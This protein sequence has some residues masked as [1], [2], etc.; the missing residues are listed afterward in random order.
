M[1]SLSYFLIQWKYSNWNLFAHDF[2]VCVS[3]V[4]SVLGIFGDED[5][6]LPNERSCWRQILPFLQLSWAIWS[7]C[8]PISQL[9]YDSLSLRVPLSFRK[10]AEAQYPAKGNTSS[11]E[12]VPSPSNA[13]VFL[14]FFTKDSSD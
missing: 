1:F 2:L 4:R 7:I 14:I 9:F 12:I 11:L 3:D 6:A 5:N 13:L 10:N 8:G